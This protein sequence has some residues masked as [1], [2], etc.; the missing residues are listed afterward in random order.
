MKKLLVPFDFSAEAN[1]ALKFALNI[2]AA[3]SQIHLL[4]VVE[5]PVMYDTV[6]MP[7]LSFEEQALQETQL[8]AAQHLEK[9]SE[10]HSKRKFHIKTDVAMGSVSQTILDH[11]RKHRI[12]LIVMGTKGASGLKE[13]TIGSNTVKIVR[14]SAVPVLAVKK[15]SRRASIRNIVFATNLEIDEQRKVVAKIQ[16]LQSYFKARLH[17]LRV[18]TP[19]NFSDDLSTQEAF[20]AFI[21]KFNFRNYTINNFNDK[22]EDA[23]IIHFTHLIKGDMVAMGTHGRKGL[24]HAITGSLTENLLN[25]IDCPVWTYAL[26]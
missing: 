13:L 14:R 26:K 18:N 10:K 24:A 12:D 19:T 22:F 15:Y 9:I 4:H 2:A 5:L 8:K 11:S 1:S 23:G 16:E 20:K 6:L 17:I 21:E 3:K 7:T 25:R